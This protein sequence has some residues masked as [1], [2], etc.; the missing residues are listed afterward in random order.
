MASD[1]KNWVKY[2]GNQNIPVFNQTIQ[3]VLSL[4]MD[5]KSS[6]KQLADVILQDAALTSRV[7]RV[8]NSPYYNRCHTQFTNIRRIVLLIGFKKISEICLTLSILDSIIDG[9]ARKH[10]YEI[11]TKSFHAAIQA[12][13]L[14]E[15]YNSKDPDMVYM[16]TLLFNIGEIAFWSL[17]GKSGRL[18]SDLLKHSGVKSEQAEKDILGITFRELSLGLVSEWKLSNLL[19]KALAKPASEDLNVKCISYANIIAD[20]I[21]NNNLDFDSIAEKIAKESGHSAKEIKTTIL[22]NVAVAKDSYQ[23]YLK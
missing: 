16:S 6:C 10:V 18:I 8:A 2:I 13:S 21:I 20:S 3:S 22:E 17:T 11:S 9:K 19:I 15:I 4:A 14:A 7:I 1:L 5:D 23:Y 12:R